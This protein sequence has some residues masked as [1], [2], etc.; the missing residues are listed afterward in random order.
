[1]S[2]DGIAGKCTFT[3]CV[4]CYRESDPKIVIIQL[5]MLSYAT[6]LRNCV[7]LRSLN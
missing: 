5:Q 7:M 1:M 6:F 2:R 3:Q 4:T